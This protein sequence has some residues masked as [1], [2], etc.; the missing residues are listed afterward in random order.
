VVGKSE[1]AAL[2]QAIATSN[3]VESVKETG[4]PRVRWTCSGVPSMARVEPY[5]VTSKT[6]LRYYF[7]RT[8]VSWVMPIPILFQCGSP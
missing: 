3:L 5:E 6:N 8:L 7:R 1:V 2:A 4:H